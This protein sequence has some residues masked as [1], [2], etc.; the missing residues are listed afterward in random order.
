MKNNVLLTSRTSLAVV[1]LV[2]VLTAVVMLGAF[3]SQ[4]A[5][6]PTKNASQYGKVP[7]VVTISLAA[8]TTL[9]SDTDQAVQTHNFGIWNYSAVRNTTDGLHASVEYSH[10]SVKDIQAYIA[11]NKVLLP[12]VIQI[13]GPTEVAISFVPLVK[14]AWFR[15]WANAKG[16]QVR[17]AQ[18]QV[19]GGA[20]MGVFGKPNDPL[21][22]ATLDS[23]GDAAISGVFGVY[24]MVDAKQLAEIAADPQVALL[25][26]TPAWVRSDLRQAGFTEPIRQPVSVLLPFG[27]MEP[28]GLQNFT[29]LPVP[30]ALPVPMRTVVPTILPVV[31]DAP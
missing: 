1:A 17:E 23:V 14:P 12:Q 10:T 20:G 25:D 28:L 16:L 18:L 26:V 22:Q 9:P 19:A 4:S 29:T 24:G 13:G 3:F 21:P 31:Q 5:P 6:T 11:A 30:T 27:Y 15:I 2:T 8:A 7:V